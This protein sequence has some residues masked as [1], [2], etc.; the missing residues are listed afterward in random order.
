MLW[1]IINIAHPKNLELFIISVFFNQPIWYSG[2]SEINYFPVKKRKTFLIFFLI[3]RLIL[4]N[5][6]RLADNCIHDNFNQYFEIGFCQSK[7]RGFHFFYST[8]EELDA[9]NEQE[10]R[11]G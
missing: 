7:L 3:F 8:V 1:L 9:L 11:R 6:A 5:I 2:S 10:F 4:A